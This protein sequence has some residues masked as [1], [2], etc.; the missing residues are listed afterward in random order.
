MEQDRDQAV[1]IHSVTVEPDNVEN[2]AKR[3]AMRTGGILLIAM[4]EKGISE[5]QLAHM[6]EVPKRQV[7]Q[8]LLGEGWK[9]Y[10]PLAALC[11]A[12]GV[13][14]DLRTDFRASSD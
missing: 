11:L 5:E 7:R 4:A 8:I 6:L 2:E 12:L 13:R 3:F 1:T 14:M 10:L 9:N